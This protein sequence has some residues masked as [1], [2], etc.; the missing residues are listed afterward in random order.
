VQ[1]GISKKDDKYHDDHNSTLFSS[2]AY[3]CNKAGC[4]QSSVH[5]PA[6]LSVKLFVLLNIY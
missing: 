4:K 5:V 2:V 3:R 6:F 1:L